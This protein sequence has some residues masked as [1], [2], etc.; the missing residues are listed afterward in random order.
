MGHLRVCVFLIAVGIV[1][2]AAAA[3][4]GVVNKVRFA[5]DQEKTIR[6]AFTGA[7]V[8]LSLSDGRK[9]SLPQTT[10]ASGIRYA[11]ADET[12]VFWSKGNTAFI[13]EGSKGQETFSGCILVSDAPGERGWATFASSKHGFSIRYPRG[14]SVDTDY[15][16][17]ALG[18]GKE[19]SG[20]AFTI[21]QKNSDGTNLSP[22]TRLTVETL[23][24]AQ[25]CTAALFLPSVTGGVKNLTENGTDYSIGSLSD[26]AAG[27]LYDETVFAVVGSAPCL[28]VRYFIHST[29]IANFDPGT[30]KE[31]D[32]ASLIKQFDRIRKT[33]IIG[34]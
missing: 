17:E 2:H 26:A 34:R 20:V 5:C 6:A 12:L 21:P 14:Y 25:T 11:N 7:K 16:Y 1:H 9:E 27:N 30:V 31:F 18:P 15:R 8:D 10:S 23:P 24:D 13:T 3:E 4:E 22:D 29:N 32:R 33:L 28:A 19:I